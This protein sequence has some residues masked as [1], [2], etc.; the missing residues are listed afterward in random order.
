M[1][2]LKTSSESMIS[3]SENN[4]EPNLPL[5]KRRR[6][7]RLKNSLLLISVLFFGFFLIE[8]S[9]RL[10]WHNPYRN[11]RPDHILKLPIHHPGADYIIDRSLIA[12]F[13]PTVQFRVD[14]RSYI[15][16]SSRFEKPDK[17]IVF[18]GGSTTECIAVEESLRF[19]VLVSTLLERMGLKINTLNMGRSG[20]TT[21]DALNVLLNHV[22]LDK[23]DIAMLMHA[24]ND[25]GVLR[26]DPLYRSRM[27]YIVNLMSQIKWQTQIFSKYSYFIA[28]LR[29]R[30]THGKIHSGSGFK[31]SSIIPDEQ[32][33][34]RLRAFVVLCRAFN[35]EPVL[36][37]QPV[38]TFK[39]E[40][41][42]QW[43]EVGGQKIFNEVI[44]E[45]GLE[46]SVLVIDLMQYIRQH[47]DY[48]KPNK[49]FY[50]GMHV[51]D[52][53]SKIYAEHI[54][55]ILYEKLKSINKLIVNSGSIK[56]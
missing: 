9:F 48:D 30:L 20:N 18:L 2:K 12:P 6:S 53:G 31:D 38:A 56:H 49:I 44:R 10:F 37:T 25:V 43:L 55:K 46:D 7:E 8:F 23:P 21:H 52:Y 35:I 36:M 42:P 27:G 13:K 33:R 1:L 3:G 40:I 26:E 4:A 32:Y 34:Q 45:V 47:P 24:S 17:T 5:L 41:S 28:F 22:I 14:D 29:Y 11:E 15:I 54:A 19:P 16:P 50:D 39:T 51:T